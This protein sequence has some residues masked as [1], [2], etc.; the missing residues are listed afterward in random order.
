MDGDEIKVIAFPIK[1]N[2]R[3]N[4]GWI[5][6]RMIPFIVI[7]FGGDKHT[8]PPRHHRRRHLTRKREENRQ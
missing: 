1:E 2:H 4:L 6:M 7:L 5:T 8:L 3:N